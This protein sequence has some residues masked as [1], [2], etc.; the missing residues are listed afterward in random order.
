MKR[1][2]KTEPDEIV[3]NEG[4][5]DLTLS[6]VFKRLKV[7]PHELSIDSLDV[8]ADFCFIHFLHILTVDKP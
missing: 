2:F 7:Q 8:S 5:Q 6:Q 1:K 3:L 4:G